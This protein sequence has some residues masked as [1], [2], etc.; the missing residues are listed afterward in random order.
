MFFK[1]IKI[2]AKRKKNLCRLLL[3]S[4]ATLFWEPTL[5]KWFICTVQFS[6]YNIPSKWLFYSS[7]LFKYQ[8]CLRIL[9]Y[10]CVC[11]C[12]CAKLLQSCLTLCDPIE[13][14]LPGSFVHGDSPGKH[15]E[16]VA[17]PSSRRSFH[18]RDWTP[19]SYICIGR[20]FFTTRAT[21]E[22]PT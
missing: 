4:M 15:M 17:V 8:K 9:K 11:V 1:K 22:A 21:W 14:S 5:C 6:H 7:L 13:C 10:L 16:W 19:V 18:P 3:L 12:V 2:L 20:R